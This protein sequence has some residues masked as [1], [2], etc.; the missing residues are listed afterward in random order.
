[1]KKCAQCEKKLLGPEVTHC[2]DKCL[3]KEIRNSKSIKNYYNHLFGIRGG[4]NLRNYTRYFFRNSPRPYNYFHLIEG[5]MRRI[6]GYF[7]K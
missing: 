2:S 1:M 5:Y 6:F 4:G 7:L 3:F